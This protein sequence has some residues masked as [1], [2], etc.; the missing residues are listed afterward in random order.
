MRNS[1]AT[2]FNHEKGI[3]VIDG[4]HV[5][6]F[7]NAL[8]RLQ[9]KA[10]DGQQNKLFIPPLQR[11]RFDGFTLQDDFQLVADFTRF[12]H[13]SSPISGPRIELGK[14]ARPQQEEYNELFEKLRRENGIDTCDVIRRSISFLVGDHKGS[15]KDDSTR[16]Q[17]GIELISVFM[18][19]LTE[20]EVYSY[21]LG[22]KEEV[23]ELIF[24]DNSEDEDANLAD[25]IKKSQQLNRDRQEGL[26]KLSKVTLRSK[27][28]DTEI[29]GIQEKIAALIEE[30]EKK[31]AERAKMPQLNPRLV[32]LGDKE[33]VCITIGGEAHINH[34]RQGSIKGPR[35]IVLNGELVAEKDG[36]TYYI[37]L[38]DYLSEK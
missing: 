26:K 33:F 32:T 30:L 31:K 10:N 7:L 8:G 21:S 4:M 37:S 2:G 20:D 36:T 6:G 38:A 17:S 23:P 14:L 9:M 3:E 12:E 29:K 28:L 25:D 11:Y 13:H 27:A 24:E 22:E 35:F 1:I 18:R 16:Y 19:I 34:H 15:H 5:I